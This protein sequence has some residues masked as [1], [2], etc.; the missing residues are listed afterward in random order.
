MLNFYLTIISGLISVAGVLFQKN[1]AADSKDIFNKDL[2][3]IFFF[4]ALVGFVTGWLTLSKLA[5]LRTAWTNS[6]RAMNK[7][8]NGEHPPPSPPSPLP[9][10]HTLYRAGP[11]SR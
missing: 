1:K 2:A 11:G 8:K 9:L 4:L 3:P 7:I 6:L 5:L 10:P